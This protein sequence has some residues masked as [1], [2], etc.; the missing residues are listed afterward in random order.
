MELKNFER[1]INPVIFA[2]GED[3]FAAGAV[4]ET[5]ETEP[6]HW[7]SWVA[8]TENYDVEV[9]LQKTKVKSWYCTCPY[10]GPICKHVVATLLSIQ[11]QLDGKGDKSS[12]QQQLDNILDHLSQSDLKKL[13][14]HLL[15]NNKALRDKILLEYHTYTGS[16]EPT[17]TRFREL[18]RQLISRYS[19]HGFIEYRDAYNF[20]REILDFL[21]MLDPEKLPPDDCVQT[22]FVMLELLEKE[23][24]VR[25]DDSDGCTGQI[26]QACADVILN[27]YP[28]LSRAQQSS[29]FEQMVHWEYASGLHDYGLSDYLEPLTEKCAADRPQQQSLLLSAL[30]KEIKTAQR[31]Y[32]SEYLS[33]RKLHL[34]NLWGRQAEAEKLIQ[35][36]MEIPAFRH[37]IIDAAIQQN[38]FD[39]ARKLAEE[40]INI[41]KTKE[42]P[43]TVNRWREVLLDIAE[44]TNDIDAI[45]TQLLQIQEGKR[46]QIDLYRKLKAT[47]S[48][49]EWEKVRHGYAKQII[50]KYAQVSS[51]A[52]IHVEENEFR[53]LFDLIQFQAPNTTM[54]FRKYMQTL[55]AA[56]PQE[57]AEYLERTIRQNLKTTGTSVYQQAIRDIQYL[58]SIPGGREIAD[59][60]IPEMMLQYKNRPSM[61]TMFKKAFNLR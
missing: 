13:I 45:R 19:A 33:R 9:T 35:E 28:K 17:V 21:H 43:G 34:L 5:E 39:Q 60:L 24:A 11:Q 7:Q 6:Q 48:P 36:N 46:F 32:R 54:L 42:H 37:R 56:F 20:V 30:E 58:Q 3:Y 41:A 15:R 27:A 23:I 4:Q 8:G 10:D 38:D 47:F 22:C 51:W 31:S 12:K 40:G 14:K 18:F 61:K 59:K 52:A 29:C 26:A 53:E 57:T 2:R 50:G 1:N 16:K 49:E 25:I 55:A 44:K